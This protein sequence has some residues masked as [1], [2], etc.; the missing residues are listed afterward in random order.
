[1]QRKKRKKMTRKKKTRKNSQSSHTPI[2]SSLNT[3]HSPAL[4]VFIN[5]ERQRQYITVTLEKYNF[6][7]CTL[8]GSMHLS[9]ILLSSVNTWCESVACHAAITA[10]TCQQ[11]AINFLPSVHTLKRLVFFCRRQHF[12]YRPLRIHY[13]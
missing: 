13:F 1:M 12:V 3:D 9:F 11:S 2:H 10:S 7:L 6:S 4:P 5:R 8:D